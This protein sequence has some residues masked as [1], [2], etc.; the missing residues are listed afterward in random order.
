MIS[1]FCFFIVWI[2]E[3]PLRPTEGYL[4]S[5]RGLQ[6]PDDEEAEG[7][8]HTNDKYDEITIDET[9]TDESP[10]HL[11]TS[12]SHTVI[13]DTNNANVETSSTSHFLLVMDQED[14]EDTGTISSMLAHQLMNIP[15]REEDS[16]M[17]LPLDEAESQRFSMNSHQIPSSDNLTEESSMAC[18][19]KEVVPEDKSY[20][21][22]QSS[23]L[24]HQCSPR[25]EETSS[26][27]PLASIQEIQCKEIGFLTHQLNCGTMDQSPTS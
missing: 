3:T 16:V 26:N 11:S 23:L 21:Q 27:A 14:V 24:A 10:F 5:E 2:L 12:I 18:H 1:S 25:K 17:A 15:E 8:N 20:S 6:D 9:I 22:S 7:R 4:E 13:N 19:Q